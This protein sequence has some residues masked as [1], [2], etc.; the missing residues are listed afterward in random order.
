MPTY[1]VEFYGN[2]IDNEIE[3][4][5]KSLQKP[6]IAKSLRIID[7]LQKY[8]LSIGMPYV[9][10]IEDNLYE[11]RVRGGEEV[12]YLFTMKKATFYIIFAFKKKTEKT[13]KNH[14]TIARKRIYNI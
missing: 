5:I 8:G 10:K 3:H 6:T 13:P 2:K 14:L 12:R 11:L 4:F 9:K 7:L 1:Q